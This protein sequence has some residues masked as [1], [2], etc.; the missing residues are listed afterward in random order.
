LSKRFW[1]FITGLKVVVVTDDPTELDQIPDV[2]LRFRK[3]GRTGESTRQHLISQIERV[4]PPFAA[5]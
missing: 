2:D 4:L 1:T 3:P 5:N